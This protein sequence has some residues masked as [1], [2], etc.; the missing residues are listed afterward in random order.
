M[1]SRFAVAKAVALDHLES[2]VPELLGPNAPARFQRGGS[3]NFLWPWRANAKPTQAI[4]YL[5]GARRGGFVDFVSGTK[6]D[7]IDLV[8]VCKAG[9]INDDTRMDAVRWIEDRFSLRAMDPEAR[10]RMEAQAKAQRIAMEAAEAR[11][12][13]ER[14]GRARR[15]FHSCETW[16]GTLVETYFREARGFDLRAVPN[17]GHSIRFHPACEYWL[18][19]Q[20]REETGPDGK[21]RRVKVA[22]GPRFP[23]MV[24][25]MVDE[26]GKIGACHYTFLRPDGRDKAHAVPAGLDEP[27][28]KMMFPETAGL[29]MRLTHGP[30]GLTMDRAAEA[31]I[32]DVLGVAEGIED[33]LSAALSDPDLRCCAA[34]SL[35]GY[36]TLHDHPAVSAFL[37]FRDNDWD[38]PQAL[39]QFD[40]ALARVRQFGKPVAACAMPAAWG[41]DINDALRGSA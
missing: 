9:V 11:R 6:G 34:G 3:W 4:L 13:K 2:L 38:N 30:S 18:G 33:A 25:A 36:M 37:L 26:A 39:A 22:P 41:K 12:V 31:G 15:F 1:T 16:E 27:K 20:Y 24:T 21:R 17:L 28:A 10:A 8:A 32:S 19:A 40:R 5:T 35:A 29:T 23:A 14:R 7:V